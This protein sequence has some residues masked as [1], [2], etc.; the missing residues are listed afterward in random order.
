MNHPTWQPA[1]IPARAPKDPNELP[2]FEWEKSSFTP[3]LVVTE[4]SPDDLTEQQRR[5]FG[6]ED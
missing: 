4:L 5:D 2:P 6:L 3:G 1:T